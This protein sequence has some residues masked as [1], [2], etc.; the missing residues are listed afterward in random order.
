MVAAAAPLLKNN[1]HAVLLSSFLA[2]V[3]SPHLFKNMA[4]FYEKLIS[5]D[6]HTASVLL[7]VCVGWVSV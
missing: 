6:A 2:A 7:G 4:D 1:A 5:M 3:N